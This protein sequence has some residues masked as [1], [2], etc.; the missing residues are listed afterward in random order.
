MADNTKIWPIFRWANW[1]LSDDLFTGI[2]NS[3]YYSNDMEIREDA[4]SIY[5]KESPRSWKAIDLWDSSG[6][7]RASIYFNSRWYVFTAEDVY[8]LN[9]STWTA[10]SLWVSGWLSWKIDDAELFNWKVYFSIQNYLY[11]IDQSAADANWAAEANFDKMSLNLS[12][13]HPLYATATFLAVGN[14][15]VVWKV[16]K[17][18]PDQVQDWILL[19]TDYEVRF[20]NELGG[21]LRVTASD[22]HYWNEIILWDETSDAANEV[23]PMNWYKFLQSCI[24]NWYH[25][26]LSDKWLGLM[27]WY[28]YYILK[29]ADDLW[30]T[31]AKNWMLV[32]DDKLYFVT[33]DWLYIYWAKNKN[34]ADVLN[35][36]SAKA[37]VRWKPFA[38]WT[39]WDKLVYSE[40]NW[41]TGHYYVYVYS[42][43]ENKWES[44]EIQTMCYFWN[45]LSEIKQSMYLR[46]WYHIPKRTYAGVEYTWNI[47]IYYR[48]EVDAIDDNP[49]NRWWHELTLNWWLTEK[50]DMRSPFATT[51][52][53][54]CRFQWIQFKFVLTNCRWTE[55]ATVKSKD[56]N[57]YSADL[58][59]NDMLD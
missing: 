57:L 3:F 47:R 13:D 23:I 33:K 14:W 1:G 51:L 10:T 56:T 29:K 22:G 35:L 4:K 15:N 11:S 27:N 58:Y 25:Y 49:E 17:E 45:S 24:Y 41:D 16:T 34:Y 52:K 42:R 12:S 20:I 48:T 28:Q 44:W 19:Q 30:N 36:W 59:Y 32:Y 53:L 6:Q 54:N 46:V 18:I 50:S 38:L 9:L 37:T 5:P 40:L 55:W 26:L 8:K 21:F 31:Y 7:I 2:K 43:N 39:D